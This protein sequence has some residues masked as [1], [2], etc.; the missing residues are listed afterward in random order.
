MNTFI[1]KKKLKREITEQLDVLRNYLIHMNSLL[2]VLSSILMVPRS[3]I[4]SL[5]S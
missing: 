2:E 3:T 1:L 5:N 4:N